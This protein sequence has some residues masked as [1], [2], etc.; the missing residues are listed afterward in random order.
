MHRKK[1][2]FK[3]KIIYVVIK[4]L[5]WTLANNITNVRI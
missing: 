2:F 3:R 1:F 5:F 4:F